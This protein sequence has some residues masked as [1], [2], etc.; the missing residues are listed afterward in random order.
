MKIGN[1]ASSSVAVTAN[2]NQPDEEDI[3]RRFLE[4]TSA[5]RDKAVTFKDPI[6]IDGL[7]TFITKQAKEYRTSRPNRYLNEVGKSVIPPEGKLS[8][9][10]LDIFEERNQFDIWFGWRSYTPLGK[11]EAETSYKLDINGDAETLI[12]NY[13]FDNNTIDVRTLAQDL[14]KAWGAKDGKVTWENYL[15]YKDHLGWRARSRF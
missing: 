14:M 11:E 6:E 1:I 9:T 3:A 5:G 2:D 10:D 8:G 12:K 4:I 7:I 13:R 15:H